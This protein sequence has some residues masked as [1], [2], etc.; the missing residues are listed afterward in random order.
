MPETDNHKKVPG[1]A[2][3]R[4]L[5]IKDRLF[6]KTDNTDS[7]NTDS[8]I[9]WINE[10]GRTVLKENAEEIIKNL[11]TANAPERR[12]RGQI[13]LERAIKAQVAW[14]EMFQVWVKLGKFA[15]LK[16]LTDAVR[17]PELSNADHLEACKGLHEAHVNLVIKTEEDNTRR[18]EAMRK[19]GDHLKEE[20]FIEWVIANSKLVDKRPNVKDPKWAEKALIK[21]QKSKGESVPPNTLS[22][23]GS[24]LDHWSRVFFGEETKNHQ[25]KSTKSRGGRSAEKREADRAFNGTSK[26]GHKAKR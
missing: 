25:P 1:F 11:L 12:V 10:H 9:E 15:Q 2:N 18:E 20:G 14:V 19:I 6:D 16:E 22:A 7:N 4:E 24:N 3:F 5:S 21:V 17:D 23:L 26:P 8:A 13:G